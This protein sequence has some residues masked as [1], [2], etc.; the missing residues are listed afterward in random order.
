[1]VKTRRIEWLPLAQYLATLGVGIAAMAF[2]SAKTY[3][4]MTD[5]FGWL[6]ALTLLCSAVCFAKHIL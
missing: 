6:G 5:V 3:P 4:N 1:M 2:A